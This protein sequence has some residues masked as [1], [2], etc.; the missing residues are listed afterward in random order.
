M[1]S[2]RTYFVPSRAKRSNVT[3]ASDVSIASTHLKRDTGNTED[4][5]RDW[6][7]PK[8]VNVLLVSIWENPPLRTQTRI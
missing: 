2:G 7:Q 6:V 1:K 5:L 3:S 4:G 8:G